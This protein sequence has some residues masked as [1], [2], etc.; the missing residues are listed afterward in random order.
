MRVNASISF[1]SIIVDLKL[2]NIFFWPT[3]DHFT[4]SAIES[5]YKIWPTF[6][7]IKL[8]LIMSIFLN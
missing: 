1:N 5:H 2:H 3:Q 8:K 4:S 7:K 6:I